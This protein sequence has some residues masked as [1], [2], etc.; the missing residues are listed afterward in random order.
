MENQNFMFM[1]ENISIMNVN[2]INLVKWL[3]VWNS[4]LPP[5]VEY[6]VARLIKPNN[7]MQANNI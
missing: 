7:K 1:N 2:I 4:T 5:S 3:L 6:I